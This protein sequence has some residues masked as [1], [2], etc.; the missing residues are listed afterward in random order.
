MIWASFN[1]G[2]VLQRLGNEKLQVVKLRK[3]ITRGDQ[4]SLHS[5]RK[6]QFNH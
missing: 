1:F 2:F 6:D 3:R 4:E 5:A